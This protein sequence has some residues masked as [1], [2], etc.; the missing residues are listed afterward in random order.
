M[1]KL[2][3]REEAEGLLPELIPILEQLRTLRRELESLQ[4]DL[5]ALHWQAR[6]NGKVS[7]NGGTL[8]QKQTQCEEVQRRIQH[9]LQRIHQRGVEVKDLELGLIDFRA[10]R[11]GRVVYL[12]WRLGEDRLRFW[13]DLDAGYAG[14]Q[15]L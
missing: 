14:R 7:P 8:E 10:L 2:F 11:E 9:E 13:H 15:P 1:D 4:R 5:V 3:T 6:G 12:C